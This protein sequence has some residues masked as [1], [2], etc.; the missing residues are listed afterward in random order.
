MFNRITRK[1]AVAAT[2][3][4]L[5]TPAAFATPM[6]TDPEPRGAVHAVLVFL[7]LA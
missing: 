2:L 4:A 3:L 6:G 5:V 1:I 7:G